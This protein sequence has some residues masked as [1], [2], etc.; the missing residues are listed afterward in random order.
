M[1]NR[2]DVDTICDYQAHHTVDKQLCP[3]MERWCLSMVRCCCAPRLS[4]FL[5]HEC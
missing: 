1:C 3:S 2:A 5:R 4:A